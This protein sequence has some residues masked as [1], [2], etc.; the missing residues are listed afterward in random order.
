MQFVLH[1]LNAGS[2]LLELSLDRAL[3][4][5]VLRKV[6]LARFYLN[7]ELS[8][9]ALSIIELALLEIK[10]L[11]HLKNSLLRRKLLLAS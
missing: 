7:L 4:V 5:L 1:L 3:K 10:V 2:K 6:L 9:G 8:S 11:T